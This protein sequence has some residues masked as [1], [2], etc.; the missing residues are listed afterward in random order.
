V[1]G[2]RAAAVW[3]ASGPL[4]G[5][6]L[7]G[8]GA[9]AA[10]LGPWLAVIAALWLVAGAARAIFGPEA[11][12]D[13]RLAV[14]YG[15][16]IAL[17]AAAPFGAVAG[18]LIRAAEEARGGRFVF[19]LAVAAAL[20]AAAVAQ[21]LTLAAARALDLGPPRLVWAL[22]TL[23]GAGALMWTAF[24]AMEALRMRGAL[25]GAFLASLAAALSAILALL[26]AAPT[27]AGVVWCFAVAPLGCAGLCAA[28]VLRRRPPVAEDAAL[29][30]WILLDGFRRSAWLASGVLFAVL[31]VWADKWALWLSPAGRVSPAGFLHYPP[32]DT[33]MF[34]AHLSAAPALVALHMLQTGAFERAV[35]RFRAAVS[36]RAGLAALTAESEALGATLLGGVARLAAAQAGFAVLVVLLAPQIATAMGFGFEQRVALRLGVAAA[37][38]HALALAGGALLLLCN[39]AQ[40]FA[41][42]QISFFVTN[43]SLATLSSTGEIAVVESLFVTVVTVTAIT[44][45]ITVRSISKYRYLFFVG[46]NESLTFSGAGGEWTGIG[47]RLAA[48]RTAWESAEIRRE[49]RGA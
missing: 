3:V 6:T 38:F 18:R 11:A 12:Q 10:T 43:F 25:V 48:A 45:Q 5:P 32:Y 8:L 28:I 40:S 14:V 21:A 24:S 20:S 27:L 41:T 37:G 23:A 15:L 16:G 36:A 35:K 9:A 34:V 47:R 33:A 39:R 2:A 31:G 1:S 29:A 30:P 19:A 7:K 4:A 26:A 17:I 44:F 49:T 13:V 42:V 22:A 46:G